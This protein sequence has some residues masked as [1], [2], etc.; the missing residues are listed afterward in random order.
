MPRTVTVLG[1][2][3]A[4]AVPDSAVVR[5]AAAHRAPTVAQAVAGVD[6]AVAAIGRVARG[7]SEVTTV[8]TTGL[9]VW[10][11]RDA[12]APGAP[13][14]E[15]FEASHQLRIRCPN[16]PEA[17][18]LVVGLAEEVGDRL[19]IEGVQL[20]VSDETGARDAAREAAWSDARRRAT[21]LAGLDGATLG[22]LLEVA[23]DDAG[24][25]GPGVFLAT[26]L[27]PGETTITARVRVTW[28]LL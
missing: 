28:Q 14:P 18:A 11:W 12:G 9:S 16:L 10:P 20:E 8:A 2:G 3:S 6:S 27:E 4:R 19:R 17:S 25:P 22:D 21:H 1:H 5:V 15:G 23:E 24:G 7:L 26:T 13:E